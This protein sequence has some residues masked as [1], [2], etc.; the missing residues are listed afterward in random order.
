MKMKMGHD[1]RGIKHKNP[2]TGSS[3]DSFLKE[4]QIEIPN[5]EA[6]AKDIM[7]KH[8]DTFKRLAEAEAAE[9]NKPLANM[10][11]SCEC[12]SDIP[13]VIHTET[14]KEISK[15]DKRA[16]QHSAGVRAELHK[17]IERRTSLHNKA[18]DLQRIKTQAL[19]A[20]INALESR[21]PEEKQIVVEKTQIITKV[22]KLMMAGLVLSLILN[23]LILVIK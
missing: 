1:P 21:K 2:H 23:V 19:E 5:I 11:P 17:L 4:Q 8:A 18:L 13:T 7:E 14:I 15:L 20:K 9:R 12:L 6:I 22:P 10:I 16:R 3:L